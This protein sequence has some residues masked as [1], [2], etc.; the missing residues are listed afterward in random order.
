MPDT[1]LTTKL[2][3]AI[4]GAPY[5][6]SLQIS[7]HATQVTAG[8]VATGALPAGITLAGAGSNFSMLSGTPTG[9]PGVYTCT[10]SLTDTAGAAVSA[11]L[12]IVARYAN[13]DDEKN[14]GANRSFAT[15]KRAW[16]SQF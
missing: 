14:L 5:E 2:P 12:S 1:W 4:I 9:P 8:S 13:Q 6:A 3:D 15:L 16:P 7:P 11:S 10:I